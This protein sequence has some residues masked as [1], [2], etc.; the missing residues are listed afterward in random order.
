[1]KTTLIIGTGLAGLYAA[2]YASNFG[3][4]IL[5]S[6]HSIQTSSSYWAQGGIASA[7]DEADSTTL[8]YDDTLTAG[9]KLNNKNTV[10][11]LVNEGPAIIQKLIELGLNFDKSE[12]KLSLGMEGGHSRRRILHLS[13]TETGKHIIDFLLKRVL[14]NEN[15]KIFENTLV[16]KLIVEDGKCLG[17]KSYDWMRK[18]QMSFYSDNLLLA[19]GGYAGIYKRSTNPH[20]STGDGI[21]LAFDGEAE[22]SNMELIQFHP[23]AFYDIKSGE[24]FLISEAVRGEGAYLLDLNKNR[25]MVGL[26][27]KAELAPRDVVAS[28]IDNTMR[29]QKSDYIYLDLRHLDAG[30]VKSRF[31]NIYKAALEKGVDITS[32]LVPVS[33]SAHYS[34]GGVTTNEDGITSI[35]NLFAAGEVSNTGVHGANRLASNSL[36]ECLVFGKR[37]VDKLMETG[38][39]NEK[40]EFKMNDE[41]F[42]VNF[43]K[44]ELYLKKK[45]L[46]SEIMTEFTGIIRNQHDL[47]AAKEKVESIDLDWEYEDN[48]YYSTRLTSLKLVAE[49]IIKGAIERDE[50]RG[51]HRRT[52]FTETDASPYN[53]I[54][55]KTQILRRELL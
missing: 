20:S 13:G 47:L 4:V 48:E 19:T 21:S 43:T 18:D 55:S 46:I 22:I 25:F 53:I 50:S 26:H 31:A 8:H 35:K 15:I 39:H 51:V 30:K 32:D 27:E 7:I 28:A 41:L 36:L 33:P 37:S 3:K 29:K 44:E 5:L 45:N 16:Y 34:I 1:M 9:V 10:N 14:A 54:Q 12:G 17:C 6:K 11:I 42:R 52:D 49:L 24:S 38:N 23:T 2:D 40:N